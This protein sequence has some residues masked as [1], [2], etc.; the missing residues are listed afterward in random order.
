M[1]VWSGRGYLSLIILFISLFISVSVFPETYVD[2]SFIVPLYIAGVFSYIL[3]AKWN[4]E[5]GA[6]LSKQNCHSLFWIKMEYWGLLFT[7]LGLIIL[8][9]NL[10]RTGTEMYITIFLAVIG[11]GSF[12]LF[13]ILLFKTKN[14]DDV[15]SNL[16]NTTATSKP[17]LNF[18]REEISKS[19]FENEDN[20]Q[21]L[22]K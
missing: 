5:L 2:L 1:I 4:G 20:S 8:A 6:A 13:G 18:V 9:Q 22:P 3:G 10:D 14:R 12:I 19:K 11:V 17:T 7:A 15:N 16:Q 21:Y